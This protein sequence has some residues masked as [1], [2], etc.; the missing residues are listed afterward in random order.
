MEPG[1]ESARP[2][3]TQQERREST[4]R[5]LLEATVESLIEGGYS[6][7]TTLAIEQRAK[8]SRGARI[9]HYPNK[10]ALLADVVDHLFSQLSDH[11]EE[12]FGRVEG[13]SDA[14]RLRAGLRMLW[15]IYRQPSYTAVL[16]LS[17]AART[18][19]ELRARLVGVGDRHRALAVDAAARYFGLD[20]ELGRNLAD[21]IH[22]AMMGLLL[23]RHVEPDEGREE[24]TLSLIEQMVVP[25]LP[26]S[27][28]R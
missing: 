1:N 6:G 24:A 22:A 4:R 5:R 19:D 21:T 14:D 16:E 23:Q 3:R 2:R 28:E 26:A 12:A 17:M 18:D 10:A 20:A 27:Q 15:S 9:H 7:T 25:H 8:V 11:Y 13:V